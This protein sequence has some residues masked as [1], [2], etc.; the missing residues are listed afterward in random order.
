MLLCRDCHRVYHPSCVKQD[1]VDSTAGFVC[2]FCRSFNSISSE[3]NKSERQDLNMLLQ[4][5]TARLKEKMP[6]SILSR[7]PPPPAKN[8]Y[9]TSVSLSPLVSLPV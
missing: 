3:Y 5:T 8:P 9:L 1:L 7:A 6:G 4:I 2:N